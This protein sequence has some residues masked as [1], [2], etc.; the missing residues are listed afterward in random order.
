MKVLS[1]INMNFP[2]EFWDI[3]LLLGSTAIILLVASGLLGQYAGSAHVRIDKKKLRNVA[4]VFS[5]LFLATMIIRI[6]SISFPQLH[7]GI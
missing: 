4:I 3:S 6:I 7:L 2:L 1:E 5:L